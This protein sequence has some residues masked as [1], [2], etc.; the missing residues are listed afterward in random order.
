MND[1]KYRQP[2]V[3]SLLFAGLLFGF[4][5]I[6]FSFFKNEVNG[7][8]GALGYFFT[9]ISFVLLFTF[10]YF[11]IS[12]PY[13]YRLIY[14]FIFSIATITEYG[15][16]SALQH[17][18]TTE[19]LENVI[20]GTNLDNKIDAM[21]IYFNWTAF[22]PCLAFIVLIFCFK[23]LYKTGLKNLLIMLL[24]GTAFFLMSGYLT[25]NDYLISSSG[26]FYRTIIGS[27]FKINY[28]YA[29]PRQIIKYQAQN[30]PNNNIVLIIDESISGNHLSLNGYSRPTTPFLD[31]LD[32]KGF[33][34]NWGLGVSG[35]TCSITSN[36]LL[37]TGITELPDTKMQL[38]N[39]PI[40]FQYAKAMGYKTFY[41]DGQMDNLWSLSDFDQQ[42]IDEYL[43]KEKLQTNND[44]E[45]DGEIA[46]R[47]REIAGSSTGNFIWVNKRG[48]HIPY[49]RAYPN[50]EEI[51]SPVFFADP[52][53][54]FSNAEEERKA[55]VNS[56]DNAVRFNLNLFFTNLFQEGVNENTLYFYTSD[57]GQNLKDVTSQGSHC[58]DTPQQ[59]VVPMFLISNTKNLPKIDTGYKSSH[60]NIFPTLLDLMNFPE[61]ERKYKYDLSLLKA[62]AADSRKRY[63]FT[64]NLSGTGKGNLLPF[65]E[66]IAISQK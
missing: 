10:V 9:F 5:V 13:I 24:S 23:P 52:I 22:V 62:T 44:F 56:H 63:Y 65:D 64:G 36:K 46:R 41:F 18:S 58:G 55:Y 1:H 30:L 26:A 47:I 49:Q 57:H 51:W 7:S 19:D 16:Y 15:Y 60:S 32:K 14:L 34:Q 27:P 66:R 35:T 29:T 3:I 61:S 20:F 8:M 25:N 6:N 11:A 39:N 21:M 4:E 17:F 38:L 43:P 42:F 53:P 33:I 54:T 50:S 12:T 28:L 31:E 48:T 45:I 40:I 59:V 2:L 37:L